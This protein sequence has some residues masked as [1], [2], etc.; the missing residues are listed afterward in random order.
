M[1]DLPIQANLYDFVSVP[2][3]QI[4][5]P[6][7]GNLPGTTWDYAN[8]VNSAIISVKSTRFSDAGDNVNEVIQC[9][10][11][12]STQYMYREGIMEGNHKV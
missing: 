7:G 3:S 1:I 4:R 6:H 12:A 10:D 5:S 2:E 8:I 9:D 11:T